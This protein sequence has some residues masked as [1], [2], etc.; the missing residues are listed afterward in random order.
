M[1]LRRNQVGDQT[2]CPETETA[3]ARGRRSCAPYEVRDPAIVAILQAQLI[4]ERAIE[5]LRIQSSRLAITIGNI[6]AEQK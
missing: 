2:L 5:D 4:I 1:H 6:A 3:P